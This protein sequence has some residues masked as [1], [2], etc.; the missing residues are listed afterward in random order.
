M[1]SELLNGIVAGYPP[2]CHLAALASAP[3]IEPNQY[4]RHHSLRREQGGGQRRPLHPGP[5]AARNWKAVS[6]R[7]PGSF[8]RRSSGL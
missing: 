8:W 5:G 4:Q 2:P 3:G 1:P 6:V 7:S